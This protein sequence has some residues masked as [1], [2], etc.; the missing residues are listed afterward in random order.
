MQFDHKYK[1]ML[2]CCLTSYQH[3]SGNCYIMLSDKNSTWILDFSLAAVTQYGTFTTHPVYFFLA[4]ANFRAF[5]NFIVKAHRNIAFDSI[6]QQ[7]CVTWSKLNISHECSNN[8]KVFKFQTVCNSIYISNDA[9]KV[10]TML[11]I[12]NSVFFLECGSDHANLQPSER[13]W[14]WLKQFWH[15]EYRPCFANNCFIWCVN[16]FHFVFYNLIK[17]TSN[18]Q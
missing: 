18:F 16:H 8:S 7:F 10:T 17:S 4:L 5:W 9:N 1:R 15:Q 3:V 13:E 11:N 14:L 12:F 6:S 2:I